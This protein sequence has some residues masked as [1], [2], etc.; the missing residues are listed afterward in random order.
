MTGNS[1]WLFGGGGKQILQGRSGPQGEFKKQ[2]FARDGKHGAD[3]AQMFLRDGVAD[4]P[5]I[6]RAHK[7]QEEV[8]FGHGGKSAALRP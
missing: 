7:Q 8:S 1:V 6:E 4:A 5:A 3:V 2:L